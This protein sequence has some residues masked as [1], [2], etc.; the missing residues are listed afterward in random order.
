MTK[1]EKSM[2]DLLTKVNMEKLRNMAGVSEQDITKVEALHDL[3]KQGKT[4]EDEEVQQL[5]GVLPDSFPFCTAYI[6]NEI[7]VRIGKAKSIKIVPRPGIKESRLKWVPVERSEEFNVPAQISIKGYEII[8]AGCH[9]TFI[10][11]EPFHQ[12]FCHTCSGKKTK[13]S[14]PQATPEP[15]KPAMVEPVVSLSS[16][17]EKPKKRRGRPP[18]DKSDKK[19]SKRS[20]KSDKSSVRPTKGRKTSK[21]RS[22]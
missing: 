16:E 3:L 21:K 22:K 2:E 18:K 5:F 9:K 19:D 15:V 10:G 8:C 17:P 13:E 1:K 4:W 20:K 12:N 11:K 14:E 6:H 7:L